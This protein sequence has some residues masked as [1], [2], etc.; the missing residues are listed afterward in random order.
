MAI[1]SLFDGFLEQR[2]ALVNLQCDVDHPTQA[3]AD[4][5]HVI[6][7]MGGVENGRSGW[8]FRPGP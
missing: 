1:F 6:H 7:E 2:P 8:F 3:M 5:L 4:L